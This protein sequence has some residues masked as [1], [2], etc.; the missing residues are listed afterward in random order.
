MR[1]SWLDLTFLHWPYEPALVRPLV[2]RE[3]ELDLFDGAAWIGLVPFVIDGLTFA[4][5][6]AIPWLS[7]FPET[8]V[9]TY[10]ID[11]DGRRAVW[12]FSLDAARWPAVVGARLG[13]GLPYYWSA[14][15]VVRKPDEVCYSSR[16]RHAES[17]IRVCPGELLEVQN[18]LEVFLTAR[19]RLCAKRRGRLVSAD[20]EHSPWPLCRAQVAELRETLIEAAG[21]PAGQRMPLA[22]FVP[23]IDVLIAKPVSVP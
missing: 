21:L 4:R 18:E 9:R 14:M 1:Q 10:V 20:I 3:L 23:R 17:H 6:P 22:H 19:F 5:A 11:P 13:Y 8:N 12:F 15:K 2:P 16:R 7:R